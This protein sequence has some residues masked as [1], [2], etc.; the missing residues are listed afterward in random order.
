MDWRPSDGLEVDDED[1]DG[2][3]QKP[4]NGPEAMLRVGQPWELGTRRDGL[5]T[6][7]YALRWT[8][9]QLRWTGEA[10][11]HRGAPTPVHGVKACERGFGGFGSKPPPKFR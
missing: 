7:V 10:G 3:R 11:C 4:S 9:R 2:L 6:V 5:A 8:A 1:L